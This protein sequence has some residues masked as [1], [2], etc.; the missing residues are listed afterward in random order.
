MTT[1]P[2][3]GVVIGRFQVPDL[4]EGHVHLLTYAWKR[5][6]ELLV[7]IG[8]GRGLAT[9]RS[10]LP[11]PVRKEM[12]LAHFPRARVVEHF[13]HPSDARWSENLDQTIQTEFPEHTV[14]LYGSRDSFIPFYSGRFPTEEVV[15]V[16]ER[17]GTELRDSVCDAVP[18]TSDFRRGIIY[19]HMKRL[20]IP[21]PVV[22]VAIVRA[23][24]NEVLLGQKET[25][26]EK[27]RF[28]GGFVDPVHDT[29]FEHAVRREAYEET[30]GIEIGDPVYLGSSI[31]KD[32][33]YRKDTDCVVSAFYE[34]PYIFGAPRPYD[35]IDALRWVPLTEILE[36][37]IP[38]H[39]AMGEMLVRRALKRV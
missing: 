25:D 8:S 1:T 4:H 15:A 10:P 9:P 7:V 39:R 16:P 17:S 6:D 35:D 29:S 26:G 27:W 19:T 13:D 22:D 12:I 32:W 37:L 36:V 20:P 21:Y 30:G 31:V 33:R 18:H 34:A 24:R 14:T 2:S 3:L 23:D 38:E 11:F 28:I 5:N